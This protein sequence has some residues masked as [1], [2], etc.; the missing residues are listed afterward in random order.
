MKLPFA[1][2]ALAALTLCAA[3]APAGMPHP[4]TEHPASCAPSMGLNFVCGLNQP[5]D[6]IQI[7]GTRWLV[8]SAMAPGGGIAIIDSAA[9]TARRFYTGMQTPDTALYLGCPR[10][11]GAFNTHGLALRPTP[12]AGLYR[13]YAVTHLP[14]ESIQ[15]FAVDA[16]KAMPA[17]SWTG[18]VRLPADFKSNAVTAFA[19]GTI[20]DDVQM[21]GT[22]TDFISGDIT[23]GVYAWSPK[24]KAI[25]LLAG[26][27][28]AGNNGIELSK[29][30]R[31][32]Y[33]AVSGTQTVV[34]F[35]KDGGKP[36]RQ[37]KTPW[38]N[39]DNIHWSGDRLI[40]AGMMFDEPACGGTRKQIQDRHGDLNCHRGWVAA[41]LD[42][43]A[44]SW[45]VLGY[46]EPN[47]A[48]GGIATALVVDKTLWL[49]SFQM[50]RVAWRPLPGAR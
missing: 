14:F 6:L 4:A 38:F 37:V 26:T 22:H 34:V 27:E 48:F 15:V 35:G 2:A 36:L 30:E 18:C 32:F 25:R 11:P 41:Q 10:A 19:D 47:P 1:A 8:A 42:P 40:A 3:A 24:T 21:H 16:R 28:L 13:L 46:G 45:Q 7:P 50:D 17:I 9:K 49:S 44:M 12:T 23:G 33:V 31:E 20:L 39:L 29:D 43:V 5:E